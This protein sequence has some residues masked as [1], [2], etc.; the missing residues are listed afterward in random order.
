LASAVSESNVIIGL[1]MGVFVSTGVN[2]LLPLIGFQGQASVTDHQVN[3]I[4][5][6]RYIACDTGTDTF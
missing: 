3:L 6:G 5:V 1:S 2:N 4:F